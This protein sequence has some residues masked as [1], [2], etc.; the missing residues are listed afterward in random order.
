MTSIITPT[1]NCGLQIPPVEPKMWFSRK[2]TAAR[3]GIAVGTLAAWAVEGLGPRHC[4]IGKFAMY[5]AD[6]LAVWEMQLRSGGG[7]AT[8][9]PATD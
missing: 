8:P 4:V 5:H 3:Y 9:P 1:C 6:D 7:N 2:E